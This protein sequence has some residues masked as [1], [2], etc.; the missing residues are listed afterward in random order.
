MRRLELVSTHVHRAADDA[1]VAVQIRTGRRRGVGAG[2]DARRVGLQA[3]IA[4]GVIH[5]EWCVGEITDA[6]SWEAA[7]CKSNLQRYLE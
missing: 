7:S 4:A 5:E 3:Q 6:R 1:R 2:V